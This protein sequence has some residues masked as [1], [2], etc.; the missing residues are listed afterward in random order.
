MTLLTKKKFGS[1][2][3]SLI[4]VLLISAGCSVNDFG[5]V[6][7]D[8]VEA[9]GA[10][11][12]VRA[13]VGVHI[14]TRDT[15]PSLSIGHYKAVHVF[16]WGE[17]EDHQKAGLSS[18]LFDDAPQLSSSRVIGGQIKAGRGEMSFTLG[19]RERVVLAR[20]DRS[21]SACRLLSYIPA[22]PEETILEMSEN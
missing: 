19:M 9:D 1:P 6:K 14:D 2:Q 15:Q 16:A 13:A 20:L 5:V 17:S 11:L 8:L 3:I 7:T 21:T 18:E 4:F 22:S 10:I 12:Y